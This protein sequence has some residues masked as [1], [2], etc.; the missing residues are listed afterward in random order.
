MEAPKRK[1]LGKGLGALIPQAP[2]PKAPSERTLPIAQIVPNPW[3]PRIRFDEAKIAEMAESIRQHGVIEPLLVRAR[4]GRFEL[5]AGERRMRA[6]LAA[7]LDAVP[8]IVREMSDREVLEVTLIENLQREELTA[9]E[10]AAA[11]VRLI[12]E[13][14]A[15]QDE[16]ARR[17]GKSRP[18]VA[19]T[20]RLLQL[21]PPVLDELRSGRLSAGHARA[22]LALESS[23]E[24]VALAR[25]TIR[26][27]LSVR[28]L[29]ERIREG[30]AP[31]E[32][33]PQTRDLHVVDVEKRL[34]RNLGTRVRLQ[35]N[36]N[37]GRIVIEYFSTSELERLIDRLGRS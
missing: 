4:S 24:Q 37:R 13:F 5:I 32:K 30:R 19:N 18:A 36:G 29:E 11:Y 27:A 35:A 17:V 10:E 25:E 23:P 33:K 12:E 7:G 22:L 16:V 2:P 20:I 1:G 26:L 15:T 28:Q 3:Q 6:A 31:R 9:L 34:M 21:P 8:V 14:G